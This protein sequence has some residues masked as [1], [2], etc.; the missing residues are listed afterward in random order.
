[1]KEQ[2]AGGKLR[3]KQKVSSQDRWSSCKGRYIATLEAMLK[4]SHGKISAPSDQ[5]GNNRD[6]CMLLEGG[7]FGTEINE[8]YS[9]LKFSN[10]EDVQVFPSRRSSPRLL[11]PNGGRELFEFVN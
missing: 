8:V 5:L 10:D 7:S 3:G 9:L 2:W 1:M 11:L 6:G 4:A